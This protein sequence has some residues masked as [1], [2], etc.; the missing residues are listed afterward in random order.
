MAK[1]RKRPTRAQME[2]ERARIKRA[3]RKSA[4][5]YQQAADAMNGLADSAERL[6]ELEDE[7]L[8]EA[9]DLGIG[10]VTVLPPVVRKEIN[11]RRDAIFTALS[12]LTS[13]LE[14]MSEVA[15]EIAEE[16]LGKE[17]TK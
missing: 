1:N 10:Q 17:L 3:F 5:K 15:Q 11:R 14:D 7:H 8:H 16:K 4:P 9:L 13:Y 2:L 6:Q 12:D